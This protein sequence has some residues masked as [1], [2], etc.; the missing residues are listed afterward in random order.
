MAAYGL[1]ELQASGRK[2]EKVYKFNNKG[3]RALN[4]LSEVLGELEDG[5]DN[6]GSV[7]MAFYKVFDEV[8]SQRNMKLELTLICLQVHF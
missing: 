8:T 6:W 7:V 3:K 1:M 4:N 5:N 2:K